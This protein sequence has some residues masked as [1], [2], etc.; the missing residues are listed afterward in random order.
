[1]RTNLV[2]RIFFTII[3]LFF[4]WACSTPEGFSEPEDPMDAGREFVRSVLDGDYEKA[5]LYL[6][7]DSE[8]LELFKRYSQHMKKRPQDELLSLRSASIIVNKVEQVNDSTSIINYSNSF[9]K[10]P[11]VKVSLVCSDSKFNFCESVKIT[12]VIK[13]PIRF[14][15]NV[16]QGNFPC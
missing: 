6:S 14:T 12:P 13:H 10:K 7:N 5:A 2:S 16:V 9:T 11:T 4:L 3:G 15:K 8:D 1:M